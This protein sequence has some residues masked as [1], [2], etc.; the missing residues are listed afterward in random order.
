MN[1]QDYDVWH[2]TF[3]ARI[4]AFDKAF[5]KLQ[6]S[7]F[8]GGDL[9]QIRANQREAYQAFQDAFTDLVVQGDKNHDLVGVEVG[10]KYEFEGDYWTVLDIGP[11]GKYRSVTIKRS[12]S[13]GRLVLGL[14]FFSKKA[15][16]VT[17]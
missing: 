9:D 4:S 3:G 7:F 17:K 12:P 14:D 1:K 2:N 6:T 5:V 15:T 16:L 13:G 10:K 8:T 11:A